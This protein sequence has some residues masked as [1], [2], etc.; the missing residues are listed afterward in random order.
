MRH[1]VIVRGKIKRRSDVLADLFL[2]H[3][4]MPKLRFIT[5]EQS[6]RYSRTPWNVFQIIHHILSKSARAMGRRLDQLILS[7]PIVLRHRELRSL[8]P[9]LC[10]SLK[11][12]QLNGTGTD[13]WHRAAL[14]L[15]KSCRLRR[16]RPL[17]PNLSVVTVSAFTHCPHPFRK[18]EHEGCKVMKS[19][20]RKQRRRAL[21]REAL[22]RLPGTLS[23]IPPGK[24]K[25]PFR[26]AT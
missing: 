21:R 10:R 20:V 25:C 13:H 5:L 16:G 19:L 6:D 23:S 9:Y 17:L 2:Y 8:L 22:S 15:R 1:L 14:T 7:G 26:G 3:V 4:T 18:A 24:K 12:L 11:R